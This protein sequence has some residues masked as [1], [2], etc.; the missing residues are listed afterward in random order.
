MIDCLAE[1]VDLI[2]DKIERVPPSVHDFV[3]AVNFNVI[4]KCKKLKQGFELMIAVRPTARYLQ[5]KVDLGG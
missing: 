5:E 4:A 3:V 1:N 2:E